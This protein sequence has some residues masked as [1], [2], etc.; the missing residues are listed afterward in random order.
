[1]RLK[2][3]AMALTVRT[4]RFLLVGAFAA[5][6][7]APASA[8]ATD[9]SG[10]ARAQVR[11]ITGSDTTERQPVEAGLEFR[12]AP[13]W[14]G[15]W[16][17]PGDAGVAP[18]LD[19]TG[20][21][22]VKTAAIAWPAPT[23]LV[24]SGLQNSVYEGRFILPVAIELADPRQPA[25]VALA[26]DYAACSN[27]CVPV[28]ADLA[29]SLPVGSG[30]ASAEAPALATARA[31]VPG[32]PAAAGIEILHTTVEASGS[33]TKLVVTVRSRTARFESPDLFVEGAGDGLP[34]AP[35]VQ[36]T[37]GGQEA[38]MAATLPA[39]RPHAPLTLTLVD[40]DRS[41]EFTS[42]P[43]LPA[44]A[45]GTSGRGW[46]VILASAL[47][48][49][50]ILNVMPCVL[51]ILSIKLFS[52]SRH[53]GAER[54]A[55]RLG[56]LATAGGI[57]A[58][59]LGLAGVLIGLKLS[60][61]A[62]GWG[63]QFQQP[64]FLVGMAVLT[65]LFAASFFEW[66]PIGLPQAF[67]RLSGAASRVA[68]V[69]AFLAG[70]F[71]T[72][73]ATPCSAP[74]V[75]TAVGFALA[76]GPEEILA[77][78]LCLGLGM[79]TPFLA[80]AMWPGVVAWLP[81][82]GAWMVRLRQGLGVLLLATAAWLTSVLESVA[83]LSTAIVVGL[84]L[85][86]LLGFRFWV[87]FDRVKQGQLWPRIGT[88]G[89]ATVAVAAAFLP[90]IGG[91]ERYIPGEWQVFDPDGLDRAVAAGNTVLVD[92]TA[93][94]CLTCKLNE[95]AALELTN[96]SRSAR[97]TSNDPHASRLEPAQP[98]HCSLYPTL[99]PLRHPP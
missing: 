22:N 4:R 23:R 73:L 98:S 53:A 11:L 97:P 62:V 5:L 55:V 66:L 57:L 10:D 64:W 28:H 63:I 42:R 52:L 40:G 50:L 47:L 21:G 71:S 38:V 99:C 59:F 39:G 72:L 43:A 68:I 85:A 60:G 58:C 19:W 17:T 18:V 76:Q 15:Y 79:A 9:W 31:R 35:A 88:A 32:S 92:V 1:M 14:H 89:L 56:F 90:A 91:A 24:V 87:S 27:I 8:A 65:T 13:G 46:I 69:E 93:S 84:L 49:G 81:K 34:P 95:A 51:P 3:L 77:V 78:F 6:G 44:P 61:A 2:G 30:A 26:I 70:V 67:V 33:A 12:Y 86:A 48:G 83:G 7:I 37:E 80:A 96:G 45:P 75:G 82:P 29:L 41:A 20:S 16:R 74:F 54:T 36:L 94:W 25:A